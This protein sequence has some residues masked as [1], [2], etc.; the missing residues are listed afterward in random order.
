MPDCRFCGAP[1]ASVFEWDQTMTLVCSE[2]RPDLEKV[3]EN[4]SEFST[5]EDSPEFSTFQLPDIF[6]AFEYLDELRDSGRTNMLGAAEYLEDEWAP[7]YFMEPVVKIKLAEALLFFW[8][9][10][11]ERRAGAREAG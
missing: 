3:Y 9:H 2:C 5:F 1:D 4:R 10:S 6:A 7:D 11:L 8:M